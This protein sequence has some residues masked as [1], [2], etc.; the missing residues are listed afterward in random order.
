MFSYSDF[1]VGDLQRQMRVPPQSLVHHS[2]ET[3]ITLKSW[4]NRSSKR[5][6]QVNGGDSKH[7]GD[8][9]TWF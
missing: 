9:Q 3:L 6:K 2:Y 4:K 7:S 8:R 5:L 1:L